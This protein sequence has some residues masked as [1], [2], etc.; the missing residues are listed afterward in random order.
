MNSEFG[1]QSSEFRKSESSSL[2]GEPGNADWEALPLIYLCVSNVM[3]AAEPL[4][5]RI[6]AEP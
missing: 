2:P 3:Q 6:T 5:M 1:I 4:M